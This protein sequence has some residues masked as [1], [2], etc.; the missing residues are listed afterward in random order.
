MAVLTRSRAATLLLS[1]P[2]AQARTILAR[3]ASRWVL[4]GRRGPGLQGLSLVV[5]QDQLGHR[6]GHVGVSF[7]E[8]LPGERGSPVGWVATQQLP[9]AGSRPS[10]QLTRNRLRLLDDYSSP[11]GPYIPGTGMSFSA[12]VDAQVGAVV[13]QVVEDESPGPRPTGAS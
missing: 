6:S 4:L 8:T 12:E 9:G 3:V 1:R 13:D 2:S 5:A 7:E 11:E 10:L